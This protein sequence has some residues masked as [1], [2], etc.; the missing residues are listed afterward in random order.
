M[1]LGEMHNKQKNK[2]LTM[3]GILLAVAA[4]LFFITMAR[5]EQ[6]RALVH[7]QSE[8]PSQQ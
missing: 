3:L 6:N 1:P 5:F 8:Q 2:N 4:V 7:D